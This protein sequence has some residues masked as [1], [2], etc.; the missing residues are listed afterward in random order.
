VILEAMNARLPVIATP[1]GAI[2]DAVVDG[3]NG[4]TVSSPPSSEAVADAIRH[5]LD[6]PEHREV[7][8]RRN[9]Q[10]VHKEYAWDGVAEQILRKYKELVAGG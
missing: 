3:E 8:G 4:V 5:Y 1:V 10:L 6:D 7:V 9:R 2:P